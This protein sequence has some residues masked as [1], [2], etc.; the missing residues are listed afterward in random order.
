VEI[1]YT[2]SLRSRDHNAPIP[3]YFHAEIHELFRLQTIAKIFVV[4]VPKP[5]KAIWMQTAVK[6]NGDQSS[7]VPQVQV[8]VQVQGVYADL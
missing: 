4:F 3:V 8:Q 7:R 6:Q 2:Y 5:K 1:Y